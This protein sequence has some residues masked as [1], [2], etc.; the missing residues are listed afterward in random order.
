MISRSASL[1]LIDYHPQ[2]ENFLEEVMAGLNASP[3]TLPCKYF[4]DE[5]GSALFDRICELP[6]YYPTR[7]EFLIMQESVEEM[8]NLWGDGCE[9]V[10]YGSGSSTKTRLLLDHAADCLA[11]YVPI[12]ISKNHLLKTA[13]QLNLDYPALQVLPVCAD[14]TQPFELPDVE[15]STRRVVYFPGSTIGNFTR[16]NA[17]QFI[18]QIARQVGSGGGLLLGVDRV[19][20]PRI[21]VSAYND[22]E[23]ITAEFNLNILTRINRELEADFDISRLIH[24]ANYNPQEQRIEMHLFSTCDQTV[25]VAGN[26]IEI[27]QGETLWTENSHK[28]TLEGVEA[29]AAEAGM[30]IQQVWTDP[31]ELFSVIYLSTR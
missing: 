21:L 16:A 31:Q 2:T 20:D 19:K 6:E 3:K 11:A 22:A 28:F 14:Y 30:S 24:Y 29:L 13:A 5:R 23:G 27:K 17:S 26:E 18:K 1:T 8:V 10:E 25:T 4:Y 7:T 9:L 12:D 15:G